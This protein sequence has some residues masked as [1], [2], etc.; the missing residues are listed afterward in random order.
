MSDSLADPQSVHKRFSVDCFNAAWELIDQKERTP[1][2][3]VTMVL[4]SMAS[5][6]HWTQRADCKPK[7]LSIGYW[8][9]SRVLSLA[10]EGG[11]ALKFGELCREASTA[12][13]PFYRAYALEALA[14]AESVLGNPEESRRLSTEALNLAEQIADPN[15]RRM[16]LDD[17]QSIG[18]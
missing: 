14:R 3:N 18:A 10:G 9:V 16:L 8:Q 6:W 15:H 13:E 5:L 7:N 11:S 17:L 4:R 2:E 12:E 1:A